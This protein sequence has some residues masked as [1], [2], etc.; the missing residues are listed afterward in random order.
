MFHELE[1]PVA[2]NREAIDVETGMI[3]VRETEDG[4]FAKR[5]FLVSHLNAKHKAKQLQWPR[6]IMGEQN[7]R[8][9]FITINART[10]C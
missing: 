4:W 2:N 9:R 3:I 8:S 7:I 1:E 10:S 5:S 6:Q